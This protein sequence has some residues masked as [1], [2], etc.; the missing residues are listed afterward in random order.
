MIGWSKGLTKET[1]ARIAAASL[2]HSETL[3]KNHF[4]RGKTYE[5]LYGIEKAHKLLERRKSRKLSTE[6]KIGISNY[7]RNLYQNPEYKQRHIEGAKRSW[8]NAENRK[9]KQRAWARSIARSGAEHWNWQGGI[10]AGEYPLGWTITF[11]EQI[12]YRDGYKC[13]ICGCSEVENCRRLSIHHIDYD[14]DNLHPDNLVSLCIRCHTK[15]NHNREYWKGVFLWRS[16][17]TFWSIFF[18][19][20]WAMSSKLETS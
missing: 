6:T 7:V 13:Q 3:K 20:S 10:S 11:K 4:M 1:D 14:K 9:I 19:V 5:E 2:V 8:V 12:R 17:S 16:M 15:T 18:Q